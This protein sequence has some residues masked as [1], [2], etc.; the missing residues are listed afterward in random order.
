MKS[1]ENLMAILMKS[2]FARNGSVSKA[3][4]KAG[5]SIFRARKNDEQKKGVILQDFTGI[6]FG[7]ALVPAVCF[8][9]ILSD[10]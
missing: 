4:T 7:N 5:K 8:G 1:I 9:V 6:V 10:D 3:I 2:S